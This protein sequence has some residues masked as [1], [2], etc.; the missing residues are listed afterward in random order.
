MHNYRRAKG[1]LMNDMKPHYKHFSPT[2][3]ENMP[4]MIDECKKKKKTFS[5]SKKLKTF[6]F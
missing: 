3:K 2:K 5:T 4:L 6:F 1:V